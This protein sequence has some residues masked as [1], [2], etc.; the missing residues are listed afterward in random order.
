MNK[1]EGR[2]WF[3]RSSWL[4]DVQLQVTDFTEDPAAWS[5]WLEAPKPDFTPPGVDPLRRRLLGRGA[6]EHPVPP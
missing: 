1:E 5:L 4:V 6:S 2:R 3:G